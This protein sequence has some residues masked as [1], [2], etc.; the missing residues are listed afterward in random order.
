MS[1]LMSYIFA[2]LSILSIW[3]FLK[4][5]FKQSCNFGKIQLLSEAD[6]THTPMSEYGDR[7]LEIETMDLKTLNGYNHCPIP[8]NHPMYVATSDL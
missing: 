8:G 7:V 4:L 1:S 2:P 6:T 5:D 3:L